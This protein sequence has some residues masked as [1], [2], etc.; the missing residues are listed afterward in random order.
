M[1]L[2][3]QT[4][5][6]DLTSSNLSPVYIR[7]AFADPRTQ[8]IENECGPT[9]KRIRYNPN[10]STYYTPISGHDPVNSVQLNHHV[11]IPSVRPDVNSSYFLPTRRQYLMRVNGVG[12]SPQNVPTAVVFQGQFTAIET[13]LPALPRE[14]FQS[15]PD[16]SLYSG[17]SSHTNGESVDRNCVQD[18]YN[19]KTFAGNIAMNSKNTLACK[20]EPACPFVSQHSPDRYSKS[21]SCRGVSRDVDVNVP[22]VIDTTKCLSLHEIIQNPESEYL[23]LESMIAPNE[24]ETGELKSSMT[25]LPTIGSFL[26]NLYDVCWQ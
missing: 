26:D 16:G 20:Q 11:G 6:H 15:Y 22:C 9:A 17:A 14:L 10:P 1:V 18:I 24:T 7:S 12:V 3:H 19:D 8:L 25:G 21:Q 13:P 4:A 5:L 23:T 2:R